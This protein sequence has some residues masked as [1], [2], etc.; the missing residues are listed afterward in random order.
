MSDSGNICFSLDDR[1]ITATP[2]ETI[3]QAAERHGIRIPRLCYQPGYRADGNCRACVVEIEGE[4]ALAA[5]C[6]RKPTQGM[7]V[8][9]ASERAT[10]ARR[11]VMELLVTD[12]PARELAHD[13]N[14]HLW[15]W[16]EHLGVKDSRFPAREAPAPDASRDLQHG[17]DFLRRETFH[18]DAD[19][20]DLTRGISRSVNLH[21]RER[22]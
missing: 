9:A 6:V 22:S 11:V 21:A 1:E 4:R 8:R 17:R 7:V 14:S 3:L 12:Q 15:Q 10:A 2:G 19:H 5:S 18:R 16:A 20:A 13:P